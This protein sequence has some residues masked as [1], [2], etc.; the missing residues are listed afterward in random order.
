MI[1]ALCFS[2]Y[3]TLIDVRTDE[4]DSYVYPVLSSYLAYHSVHIPPEKL[5]EEYFGRIEE[6]FETSEEQYPE[7]DIHTIFHDIM[8]RYSHGKSYDESVVTD[9]ALLF[10]SLTIR[11]FGLFPSLLD[12]LNHLH[13]DFRMAVVSDAQW[14]FAEP[15]MDMLDLTRFFEF[16]IFS[17]RFGFKKNDAR[18]FTHALERLGVKPEESIYIGDIKQ[19]DLRCA[20]ESGMKCILFRTECPEYDDHIAEGCFFDYS[21]LENIINTVT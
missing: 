12:T 2:L 3:G 8:H 18:L 9:T 7:V 4:H 11:H 13:K 6:H 16:S 10:R 5:Q 20:K 17:S 14:V 21:V 15:E 1:K 19:K